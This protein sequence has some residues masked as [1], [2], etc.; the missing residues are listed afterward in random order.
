MCCIANLSSCLQ[1]LLHGVLTKRKSLVQSIEYMQ[2]SGHPNLTV[3]GSGFVIHPG[4]CWLGASPDGVVEDPV[5]IISTGLLEIKCPYSVRDKLLGEACQDPSFYC[6]L[7]E[8]GSVVLRTNHRYYHQVQLQMYV[9][10][11]LWCDF[12]LYTTK[13]I[14]VQRIVADVNWV[15]KYIPQLEEYYNNIVPS[16]IVYPMYKPSYFL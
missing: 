3:A 7:S 1:H 10:S 11:Y 16:E 8:D 2:A 13:D 6:S 5:S 12:C 14:T 9:C 4:K 15:K